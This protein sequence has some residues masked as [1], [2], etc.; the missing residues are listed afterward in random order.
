MAK[1]AKDALVEDVAE[2]GAGEAAV[3][4]IRMG[5]A[6]MCHTVVETQEDSGTVLGGVDA[7]VAELTEETAIARVDPLLD[8]ADI[9]QR[10]VGEIA[11]DVV[12]LLV[13]IRDTDEG[14]G[15]DDVA[16]S[17]AVGRTKIGGRTAVG[18]PAIGAAQRLDGDAA[19]AFV[20]EDTVGMRID[21]TATDLLR[22]DELEALG[23]EPLGGWLNGVHNTSEF[24]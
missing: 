3:G 23:S 20:E 11:V 16:V 19:G 6:E 7:A 4:V 24:R 18:V 14:T 2:A 12:A 9:A 13:I 8:D 1:L 21:D 22:R 17:P 5:G 15:D 10:E